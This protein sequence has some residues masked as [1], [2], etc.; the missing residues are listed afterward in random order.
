MNKSKSIFL[1]SL[2]LSFV[3]S[4]PTAYS[5]ADNNQNVSSKAQQ[6]F[7]DTNE[8][9]V[10]S[11]DAHIEKLLGNDEQAKTS[12]QKIISHHI[13]ILNSPDSTH[14]QRLQALRKAG[15][16][17]IQSGNI[18]EAVAL[19]QKHLPEFS[20]NRA[21]TNELAG[22]LYKQ[23]MQ[24]VHS[25]E[26]EKAGDSCYAILNVN[27]IDE[28]WQPFIKHYLGNLCLGEG[29]YQEA[30]DWYN[31]ILLEHSDL[32]E[33]SACAYY[34]IAE[35]YVMQAD[36]LRAKENLNMV[37]NKFPDSSWAKLA[38]EKLRELL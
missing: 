16:L 33:W 29:N 18:D 11:L 25:T 24:Y 34:S 20:E 27:N 6:D 4:I 26:T 5:G 30:L 9:V 15:M 10:D 23:A 21:V 38:T 1:L 12:Y 13:Q 28:N 37:I 7:I 31:R 3:F 19:Y 14:N 2:I 22:A 32:K 8:F 35:C 17:N 36:Y